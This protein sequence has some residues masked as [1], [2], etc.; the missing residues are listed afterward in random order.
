MPVDERDWNA[1]RVESLLSVALEAAESPDLGPDD[2]LPED[3]QAHLRAIGD[4]QPDDLG[5]ESGPDEPE[6]DG[7]EDDFEEPEAP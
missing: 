1:A 6:P 2:P 4:L 5:D 3:V 7:D